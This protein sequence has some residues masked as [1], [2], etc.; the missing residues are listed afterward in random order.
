M[1]KRR[2]RREKITFEV[3]PLIDVMIVLC[4]FFAIAAFLPQVQN[5]IDTKLPKANNSDKAKEA[6]V[7]A[8]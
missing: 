5:A 8:V 1:L 2:K 7:V 4:L 6:I 3:I